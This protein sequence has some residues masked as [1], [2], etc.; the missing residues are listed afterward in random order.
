MSCKEKC[1]SLPPPDTITHHNVWNDVLEDIHCGNGS[2]YQSGSHSKDGKRYWE[3]EFY[4]EL[5][6]RYPVL[7][8]HLFTISFDKL[9]MCIWISPKVDFLMPCWIYTFSREIVFPPNTKD[10]YTPKQ[11]YG[12]C[13]I[14][15][16]HSVKHWSPGDIRFLGKA[17][18][19]LV[20]TDFVINSKYTLFRIKMGR[21]FINEVGLD[22]AF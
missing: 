3:W 2:I 15:T 16:L 13:W 10:Y 21:I 18:H 9:I 6:L 7:N 22:F 5:S 1:P 20:K 4:N 11:A 17:T 12:E 8:N 14:K 19:G